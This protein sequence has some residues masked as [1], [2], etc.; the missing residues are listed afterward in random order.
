MIGALYEVYC[1][2][3]PT[4]RQRSC[5]RSP[6]IALVGAGCTDCN[7]R[8]LCWRSRRLVEISR[9]AHAVWIGGHDALHHGHKTLLFS[10]A[11]A[12][13][14]IPMRDAGGGFDV[15]EQLR[16][17][18]G[19]PADPRAAILVID[20][21]LDK[22][23]GL[24]PLERPG[25]CGPIKRHVRG[26]RGLIGGSTHR[27]RR[28]QAVLQRRYGKRRAFFLEQRDVN[29]MQAPD[30]KSRP[31]LERPGIV[32]VLLSL[33]GHDDRPNPRRLLHEFDAGYGMI[34][35]K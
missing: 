34:V 32:V 18:A 3:A 25:C 26:Q 31:L 21:A 12:R 16:A 23:A 22:V 1:G 27:Q 30:Q 17:G 13:Q 24:Q 8:R 19:Q 9:R 15:G 33:P 35:A 11:E 10:L 5:I 14:R 4:Q 28:K 2:I 7:R 29:L 6:A 20:G